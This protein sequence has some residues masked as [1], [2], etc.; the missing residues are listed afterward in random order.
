MYSKNGKRPPENRLSMC[1]VLK[2][3]TDM[4]LKM[5]ASTSFSPG[6]GEKSLLF[7]P[8]MDSEEILLLNSMDAANLDFFWVK[9]TE[10]DGTC[11]SFG[12]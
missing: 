9:M 7:A 11:Y 3:L 5:D 12:I 1:L 2:K 10:G 4:I 8:T 6:V